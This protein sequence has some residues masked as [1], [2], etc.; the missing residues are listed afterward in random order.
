MT[1]SQHVIA[2]GR[3]DSSTYQAIS[4]LEMNGKLQIRSS[5]DQCGFEVTIKQ[6]PQ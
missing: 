4:L 5:S 3:L 2:E 1:K 6:I